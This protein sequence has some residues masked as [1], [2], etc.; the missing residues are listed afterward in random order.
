MQPGAGA[1]VEVVGRLVEEQDVGPAQQQ[2]GQAEAH[3]LAAGDLAQSAPEQ[4][5]GQAEALELGDGALLGV[6]AVADHLDQGRGVAV[7]GLEVADRPQDGADA[8]EVVDALGAVEGEVLRQVADLAHAGDRAGRGG[9]QPGG[10][11][12]HGGLAGAVGADQP[13]AAGGDE[14]V[15]TVEG[16]GAVGP[17]QA[18]GGERE[19]VG[20]GHR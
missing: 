11:L 16:D 4:G 17:G 2:P 8:Q 7:A 18:D 13:G 5:A 3:D 15:E 10:Q 6:P 14:Q 1:G 12:E 19:D 9:E 20:T